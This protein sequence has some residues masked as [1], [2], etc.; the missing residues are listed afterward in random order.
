MAITIK[1]TIRGVNYI[2][3][4]LDSSR[5]SPSESRKVLTWLRDRECGRQVSVNH[6]AFRTE[7][8]FLMFKLSWC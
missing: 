6:I 1:E 4:Q 3:V 8:E 2:M 7:E 5:M